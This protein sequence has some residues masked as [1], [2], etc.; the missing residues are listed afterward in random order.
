MA[1]KHR[2]E[3]HVGREVA[4]HLVLIATMASV[5]AKVIDH[6]IPQAWANLNPDLDKH[7]RKITSRLLIGEKT[8]NK[9]LNIIVIDTRV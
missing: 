9:S 1:T 3:A 2:C 8:T 6:H 5:T 4:T 7:R